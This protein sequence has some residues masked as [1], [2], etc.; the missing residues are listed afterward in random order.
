MPWIVDK[1]KCSG[2]GLCVDSAPEVFRMDEDEEFAECF[3][4][5]APKDDPEACEARD[6]CPEEAIEWKD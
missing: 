4:P 3:K 6:D 5:D 1:E 2:C